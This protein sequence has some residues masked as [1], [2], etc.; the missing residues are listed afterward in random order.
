MHQVSLSS[1]NHTGWIQKTFRLEL[2]DESCEKEESAVDRR[3]LSYNAA[4]ETVNY[5]SPPAAEE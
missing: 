1:E 2:H 4:F 5:S 3:C